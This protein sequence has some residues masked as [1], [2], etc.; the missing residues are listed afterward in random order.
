[1]KISM[2]FSPDLQDPGGF[3][4]LLTMSIS[5]DQDGVPR[6]DLG[7]PVFPTATIWVLFEGACHQE[8]S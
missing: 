1:M 6:P 3:G 7:G 2:V 4:R 5:R 8:F